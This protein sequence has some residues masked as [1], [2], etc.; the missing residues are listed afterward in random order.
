VDEVNEHSTHRLGEGDGPAEQRP[1]S[2]DEMRVRTPF[3]NLKES[4]LES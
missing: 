2:K 4:A 3:E 1:E